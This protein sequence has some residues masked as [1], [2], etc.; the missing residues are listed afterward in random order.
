M[1]GV[2]ARSLAAVRAPVPPP[3]TVLAY[4]PIRLCESRGA[5]KRRLHPGFQVSLVIARPCRESG[6]GNA[7]VGRHLRRR[8]QRFRL[9][10]S[11][12]GER[13][14]FVAC[15]ELK[16][17]WVEVGAS[18]RMVWPLGKVKGVRSTRVTLA[19]STRS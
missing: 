10:Q 5:V 15:R 7:P 14:T 11:V 17:V 3:I 19:S 2:T 13:G 4:A 6:S 9:W 1:Q 12:G 8:L 16:P 18:T